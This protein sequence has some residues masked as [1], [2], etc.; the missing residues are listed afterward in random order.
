MIGLVNV[1]V[2]STSSP[3]N[4]GSPPVLTLMPF[5]TVV[6]A[7][8]LVFRTLA[9]TASVPAVLARVAV[10]ISLS[11]GELLRVGTA[12]VLKVGDPEVRPTSESMGKT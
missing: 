3:V 7:V 4:D 10:S 6:P 9:E 5:T 8:K 12:E 1:I 11:E 2:I